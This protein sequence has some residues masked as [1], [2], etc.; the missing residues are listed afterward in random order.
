VPGG[1][2]TDDPRNTLDFLRQ[3]ITIGPVVN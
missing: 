1:E 2:E 3:R